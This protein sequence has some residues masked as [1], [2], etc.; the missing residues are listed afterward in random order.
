M[1]QQQQQQ[2]QNIQQQ[3]H[4]LADNVYDVLTAAVPQAVTTQLTQIQQQL[5][6]IQQQLT[7][8]Q[9]QQQQRAVARAVNS[10]AVEAQTILLRLELCKTAPLWC[11][12]VASRQ[13]VLTC[14]R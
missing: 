2:Q 10:S 4:D 13:L 14:T 8:I 5:T 1:A 9:Q 6:Q 7:Q 11:L 3:L 12:L